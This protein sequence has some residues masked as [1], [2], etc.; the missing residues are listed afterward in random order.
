MDEKSPDSIVCINRHLKKNVY[1][2]QN[3]TTYHIVSCYPSR[4][5]L[6]FDFSIGCSQL[7]VLLIFTSYVKIFRHYILHSRSSF[8]R[9]FIIR[10]T[11]ASI[12]DDG[13]VSSFLCLKFAIFPQFILTLVHLRYSVIPLNLKHLFYFHLLT[14]GNI[15]FFQ[16]F[17]FF[18]FEYLYI[19]CEVTH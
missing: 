15:T 12:N 2:T 11:F 4:F 8:S 9:F 7:S 17:C 6:V 10:I 5:L 18:L 19:V 16:C 14:F 13:A 1:P 3:S